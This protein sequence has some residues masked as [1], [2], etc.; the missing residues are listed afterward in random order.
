MHLIFDCDGVLID[1]EYLAVHVMLRMLEPYGYHSNFQEFSS[2]FT[3]MLD[4]KIL[5]HIAEEHKINFP[6]DFYQQ[7]EA[8]RDKTFQNELSPIAGM[9]ELVKSLSV[10]KSVVSNSH[11]AHVAMAL[12][13]C[14]LTAE[15]GG[16]IYSSEHVEHPKPDPAVYL[17]ALKALGLLTKDVCVIEDSLTGVRSAKGAGCKVIG[18]LGGKHI[19]PGHGDKLKALGAD[20]IAADANELAELLKAYR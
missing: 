1:S 10:P 12:E 2:A 18:F 9:P 8:E 5:A 15:F 14:D 19:A 11:V 16:R 20:Q 7:I 13:M 4:T 3:G 17:F 6:K